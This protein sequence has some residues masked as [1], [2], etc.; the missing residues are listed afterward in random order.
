MVFFSLAG[1]LYSQTPPGKGP[2]MLNP[3]E[4]E[5]MKK[6]INAV[7]TDSA[8]FEKRI[9]FARK[10]LPS[11]V[12]R[13]KSADVVRIAPL[14]TIPRIE[15]TALSSPERAYKE[16]DD[17]F[18]ELEKIES[19]PPTGIGPGAPPATGKIPSSSSRLGTD[20]K[21][22]LAIN[23]VSKARLW[24]K[25]FYPADASAS[26]KYPAVIYVVGGL[27]NGSNPADQ[28]AAESAASEGFV[29][30]IFDPDGRGRSEG[31]EDWNGSI[32][33]EGLRAV[34]QS[35]SALAF[36]DR[37]NVG[38]VTFSYGLSLGAGVLG[39]Y[40]DT[41]G[42]KYLIDVEGPSDRHIITMNDS[43]ET[44]AL[45]KFRPTTDVEW[46][47]DREPVLWLPKM[48]VN[49]VRLQNEFDHVQPANGHAIDAINAATNKR[50]GGRGNCP[51][52]R[53]NGPEN[54][55]NRVYSKAAA[56][57]W[58]PGKG[59]AAPEVLLSYVKEMARQGGAL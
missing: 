29:A 51:W 59:M 14:G 48:R 27:G 52:T 37:R 1:N 36:V 42:V 57:K 21:E 56:P 8:N 43:P 44:L 58:L 35:V 31:N 28:N 6:D 4:I 2:E 55:P 26:R 41:L 39:R 16:L 15:Q 38:I 3:K 34:I 24:A 12:A 50:Y 20:S 45:M 9:D 30:C 47:K 13:G 33:Q 25:A 22:I 32:Q 7:K 5:L 54:E 53:I 10:W 11:L 23:P 49:Y 19:A 40:P 18:R 17:V 46:W